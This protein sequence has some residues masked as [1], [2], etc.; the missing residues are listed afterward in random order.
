MKT[1]DP[2]L[3]GLALA[4]VLTAI[5][6][7]SS[8]PS[9]PTLTIGYG[10]KTLEFNWSP[11]EDAERYRL[12]ADLEGNASFSQVGSDLSATVTR[13]SVPVAVHLYPWD[14]A[15]YALEACNADG[16]T[17]SAEVSPYDGMTETIGYVKASNTGVDDQFGGGSVIIGI[18]AS[19]SADGDRIAVSSLFEDSAATGINGDESNNSALDS[20]AVYIF[21]RGE[22]GWAQEAYV[23]ASNTESSDQFGHAVSLSGDGNTLA[24]GANLEASNATGINGDQSDNSAF[25]AGAAYVYTREGNGWQQQAYVKASNTD[26]SDVF[27]YQL[28][29]S[30]DGN[31]LAVSAQGEDSASSGVNFDEANNDAG[32]AGAAYVFTRSGGVWSQ[33]AYLKALYPEENDLFG[34]SI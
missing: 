8:P 6:A 23:K 16:C 30:F 22:N 24:V 7:C 2:R 10:M 21:S 32:G 15:R 9:A 1:I 5:A 29:L 18:S 25:G 20:G 28:A 11:V 33:Q 4:G 34:T 13:T 26:A 27:G 12:L 14:T 31:T 19:I 17:R 3:R